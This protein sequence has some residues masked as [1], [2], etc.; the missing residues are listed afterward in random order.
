MHAARALVLR[1]LSGLE[2]RQAG[3]EAVVI[4]EYADDKY[5]PSGLLLGFTDEG[6]PL[7]ILVSLADTI[8]TR[9]ITV[10]EPN[11]VEWIDHGTRR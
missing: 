5:S 8:S 10:Y 4:E 2:I 3:A 11:P 9:T 1:E 7:H 6:R